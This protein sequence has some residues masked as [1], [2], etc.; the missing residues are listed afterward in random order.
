MAQKAATTL[1]LSL[2]AEFMTARDV[3]PG[4]LIRSKAA[5]FERSERTARA[6]WT[7]ES[8]ITTATSRAR[9]TTV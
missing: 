9:V 2:F 1:L 3:P 4:D 8:V 7:V 6:S 5:A